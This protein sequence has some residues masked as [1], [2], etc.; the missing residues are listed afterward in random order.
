MALLFN[1]PRLDA[2]VRPLTVRLIAALPFFVAA[3][4]MGT[5]LVEY[6][7]GEIRLTREV[8][9]VAAWPMYEALALLYASLLP[10]ALIVAG[11]LRHVGLLPATGS[12]RDV[13]GALLLLVPFVLVAWRMTPDVPGGG[14]MLVAFLWLALARL[15]AHRA[16][17]TLIQDGV[18]ALAQCVKDGV[19]RYGLA[20]LAFI[21][22]AFLVLPLEPLF[23]FE[24]PSVEHGQYYIMLG[25]GVVYFVLNGLVELL[26]MER[27][28]A[29]MQQK[30]SES[31]TQ[32]SE[33]SP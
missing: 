2:P 28:M 33:A 31:V 10:L 25:I 4:G 21:L 6:C 19:L 22:S 16:H 32:P 12:R 11:L 20:T 18:R 1:P 9:T 17:G 30:L 13:L 27:W 14:W 5:V 23:G 3:I 26:P 24:M 7:S 15:V 8:R 29:R